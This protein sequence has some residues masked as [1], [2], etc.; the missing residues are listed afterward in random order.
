MI[1]TVTPHPDLL[2]SETSINYPSTSINHQPKRNLITTT[3]HSP[4]VSVILSILKDFVE[5][6]KIIPNMMILLPP[7]QIPTTNLIHC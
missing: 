4:L 7:I 1:R 6:L 5:I 2:K 3:P